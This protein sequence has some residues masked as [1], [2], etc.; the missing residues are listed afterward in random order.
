MVAL[1]QQ[2]A[3]KS[4]RIFRLLTE[5]EWVGLDKVIAEQTVANQQMWG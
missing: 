3:A 5:E 2:Q 4:E 1:Q